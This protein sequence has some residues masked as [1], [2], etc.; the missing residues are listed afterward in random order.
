[1]SGVNKKVT[2]VTNTSVIYPSLPDIDKPIPPVLR[3][4]TFD[5]PR[6]LSKT[7]EVKATQECTQQPPIANFD[8]LC[9]QYPIQKNSNI[10]IGMSKKD[11]DNYLI[12]EELKNGYVRSLLN[13]IDEVNKEREKWRSSNEP[14]IK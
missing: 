14:T 13:R 8:Y 7:K 10:F 5:Y 1:L 6:D 11:F 3:P 4:V 2:T 12:N 9:T